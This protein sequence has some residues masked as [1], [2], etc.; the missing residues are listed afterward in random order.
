MSI[1]PAQ[2]TRR[3]IVQCYSPTWQKN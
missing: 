1:T 2:G 3:I